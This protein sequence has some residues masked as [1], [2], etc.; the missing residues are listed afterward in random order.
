MG[1]FADNG[2][3]VRDPVGIVSEPTVN[4]STVAVTPGGGF[5]AGWQATGPFLRAQR[6]DD[7][8]QPV[9]SVLEIARDFF[10]QL[11]GIASDAAGGLVAS[12]SDYRELGF[13]LSA[14]QFDA[15]DVPLGE[16]IQVVA[17]GEL[18]E[19]IAGPKVCID[20]SGDFV[21][22]WHDDEHPIE[23][24]RYDAQ[25]NATTPRLTAGLGGALSMACLTQRSIIIAGLTSAGGE[26][27]VIGRAF[28]AQ[29]RPFGQF[30][31]PVSD[32]AD[33][34]GVAALRDNAF[35]AAWPSCVESPEAG[36]DIF[37][38]RFALTSGEDCTGDCKGDGVV[39][40]DEIIGSVGLA[41][42]QSTIDDAQL[43]CSQI[44]RCPAIDTNLDCRVTTDELLAAV[45]RAL[46]SLQ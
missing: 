12:W 17:P 46:G 14:R 42:F 6:Y 19:L 11:G 40:V 9:G 32:P 26:L 34:P 23:F 31:I 4:D 16:P 18:S 7:Q 21:V 33:G 37:A 36:C 2:M 13:S 3:P 22:A 20:A 5:V 8:D 1:R 27:R 41:L 15:Q 44:V 28:D 24:R 35:V 10:P 25:G 45:R 38:Q 30:V 29:T 39:T 43:S